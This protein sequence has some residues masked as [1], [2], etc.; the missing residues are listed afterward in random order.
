MPRNGSGIFN[1]ITNSWF[2]P[3]NGILATAADFQDQWQD[4]ASALTQSVSADGQTPMTGNLNMGGNQLASLGAPA[5]SGQALRWEQLQK[6]SDI[7]SAPAITIPNEGA[8]FD[9]TGTATIA[10][11]NDVF[12]GRLA[13]LRFTG[14]LRITNSAS[15]ILPGGAD[16]VTQA[17]DIYGFLNI[18]PGIWTAVAYPQRFQTGRLNRVL[19]FGSSATYTPDQNMKFVIVKLQG[20]GGAGGGSGGVSGSVNVSIGAPGAA[21][22]FAM[23]RFTSAQVGTSIF[24]GVGTGGAA[25]SNAAGGTGGTSSFGALLS[26]TGGPGG[27]R[28]APT[29][30]PTVLGN[31]GSASV[32]GSALVAIS[33][34]SQNFSEAPTALYGTGGAGGSSAYGPGA[35]MAFINTNGNSS[36]TPGAGGSGTVVNA[37]GGAATGG[38]GGNGFAELWEYV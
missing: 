34:L 30:A 31:F 27:S 38:A 3:V 16:A 35:Q 2:P 25:F 37:N 32:S 26:A 7:A 17:G 23:G 1:P 8:A 11:I 4:V 20:A 5:G 6:G 10:T 15:L 19:T 14:V 22:A 24:V 33:G 21:G 9:V 29:A 12:P 18:A 36:F 13:Y 28:I